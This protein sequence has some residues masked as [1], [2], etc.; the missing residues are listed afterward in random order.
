MNEQF[1]YYIWQYR[2]QGKKLRITTGEEIEIIKPGY[3]NQDAGP[4]FVEALLRITPETWAGNIEIHL[5]TSDWFKH[6]HTGDPNYS[7]LILHVVFENDLPGHEPTACPT[8]ELK[9]Y[10]EPE[11]WQRYQSF[12]LSQS[13]IPCG[14]GFKNAFPIVVHSMLERALMER[15]ERKVADIQRLLQVTHNNIAESFYIAMARAFGLKANAQAF[16]IL[17]RTTPLNL[18]ARYAHSLFQTESLLFGQ[19]KLLSK[20]QV[21]EYHDKLYNEYLFLKEKHQLIAS[22]HISWKFMRMH[23]QSFPT[24]RIAQFAALIHHSSGLLQKLMNSPDVEE[25]QAVL[26]CR[27]SDYWDNHYR[28]GELSPP[29]TKEAGKDFIRNVII[30]A[31]I[32][33]KWIDSQLRGDAKGP[34]KAMEL[35]YQLP[36]ENNSIVRGWKKLG[37]AAKDAYESQALIELKNRYCSFKR[38][39]ECKIGHSLLNR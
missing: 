14:E 13:W 4:D 18:L 20:H 37:F 17:A 15:L 39:L 19:A 16:E 38:C 35:L 21:D 36:P 11:L 32:P 24:L 10:N 12:L 9:Q 26:A 3:R 30:N 8:L 28:F 1:L 27:A 6:N 2:L 25:M 34:E 7:S 5:K 22:A 31:V 33:F 23:P 29:Q